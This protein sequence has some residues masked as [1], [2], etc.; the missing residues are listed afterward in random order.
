MERTRGRDWT[1]VITRETAVRPGRREISE[2]VVVDPEQDIAAPEQ[3]G[4]SER[5]ASCE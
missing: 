4:T 5:E 2:F 1:R 3:D